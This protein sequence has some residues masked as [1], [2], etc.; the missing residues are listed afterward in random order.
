MYIITAI[1]ALLFCFSNLN[2]A[3]IKAAEVRIVSGLLHIDGGLREWGGAEY[4]PVISGGAHVT[5]RGEFSAE[6]D[7]EA[8]VY[9]MWDAEFL[10]VAALVTDDVIDVAQVI[11]T[12][13]VWEGGGMRKDRMFFY[14]HFRV[15]VQDPDVHLGFD[16]WVAPRHGQVGPY[17]WGGLQ[18]HPGSSAIS[19]Q[20]GS[21][22]GEQV[23]T[24]ELA[25]PWSWLEIFPQSDLQLEA[26]FLLTDADQPEMEMKKKAPLPTSHIL[27]RGR[28][29]LH[30]TPLGLKAPP[31]SVVDRIEEGV[32]RR[33]IPKIREETPKSKPSDA[34]QKQKADQ[35]L[36]GM[37]AVGQGEVA[38]DQGLVGQ[39][40]AMPAATINQPILPVSE[41][42]EAL[43]RLAAANRKL[44]AKKIIV[45]PIWLDDLAVGGGMS[46]AQKDSLFFGLTTI[47]HRLVKQKID[48]R[49][50]MLVIDLA[51]YARTRRGQAQDFLLAFLQRLGHDAESPGN[52]VYIRLLAEAHTMGLDGESGPVLVSVLCADAQ[53]YFEKEY[54]Q[55]HK[56]TT[57]DVLLKKAA[58]KAGISFADA[59][60]LVLVFLEEW[61]LI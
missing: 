33:Q 54:Y 40:P 20:F 9:L 53:D 6:D 31:I 11:S 14:D 16:I 8:D 51:D 27:W 61:R 21:M 5:V 3:I 56:A 7:H 24:F 28:I 36:G 15:F 18:R 46:R 30:G 19:V 45:P 59:R 23:Y 55:Q 29:Q 42:M 26:M 17:M 22:A 1:L 44:L 37:E 10:Y 34:A 38:V 43:T 60:R 4:L 50:H 25:I 57:T 32:K 41:A 49:T 39:S 47:L 12:E 58:D 13:R 2:A 48:S 35:A 52:P